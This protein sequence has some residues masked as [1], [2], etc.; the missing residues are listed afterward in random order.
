MEVMK[1]RFNILA[2]FCIILFGIAISPKVLQNDT[3]Y[4]IKIG[5]YIMENGIGDL[6][7][8]PFSWHDLTYTFPHWL[9]DTIIYNIYNVFGFDGL[10]FST[11]FFTSVLGLSIYFVARKKSDNHVISLIFTLAGMYVLKPYIAVRAQLVTFILFVWTIYFIEKFI[12]TG[13]F[14]YGIILLIIPTLIANL[15]LAVWPFYFV[16]FLPYIAEYI[17]SLNIFNFDLVLKLKILI[18]KWFN[19]KNKD[20]KIIE[21]KQK[22]EEN[23]LKREKINKEPYKVIIKKEK[24]MKFLIV[25][26]LLAVLTGLFTPTHGTPYTYLPK[27]L[28]GNTTKVINE[29]LPLTIVDADEFAVSLIIFLGLLIFTDT[30]IRL[31][32]FLF[33]GG[34]MYL[35]LK[36]RR[37]ISMFVIICFPILVKLISE[38]FKKHD[39]KFEEK[40]LRLFTNFF[41]FVISSGLVVIISLYIY[42]PQVHSNYVEE[43]SYP[44]QASKWI[45]ENLNLND[46]R[47]FN[48]Y[49]YG[50]Y[51]LYEGIPVMVDSRAD[52]Y[53][54]E[55]NTKTG[56]AEDGTDIFMD[57]QNVVT[58]SKGYEKVFEEYKI[59]HVILYR[60]SKLAVSLKKDSK[61]NKIYQD[62]Y[63]VIFERG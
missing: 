51:L 54:P 2:I 56:N 7:N 1:K 15:H 21:L 48:E 26:F 3:F 35:A 32:D 50:S 19:K 37:Q 23:K 63:F 52:L 17:V 57:V 18:N 34:L 61:Y 14:K 43:A 53:A 10:Y 41:G 16:L 33:F 46:I 20:E 4:T 30:K 36:T 6:T 55:F 39:N 47:L 22:I 29:H 31:R 60:N 40:S 24:N 5:E 44:V 12:E 11:I 58:L 13:K 45:K 49:N 59:T 27:T 8:D 42:K 25:I 62:D 28:Q 9:Y 38:L